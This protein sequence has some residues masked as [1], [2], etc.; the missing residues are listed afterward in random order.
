MISGGG[1]EEE[2]VVVSESSVIA[3]V[4]NVSLQDDQVEI[5]TSERAMIST[6]TTTTTT[7][8]SQAVAIETAEEEESDEHLPRVQVELDKLNYANESI[9]S[10]ELELE[11][12][13]REYLLTMEESEEELV[14]LEKRLGSCVEKSRPYYEARIDLNEAKEKYFKVHSCS[15]RHC[16][17]FIIEY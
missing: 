1:E 7:T 15:F 8:T 10:L 12:S 4:V 13:K 17:I 5:K 6:T 11:E 16:Q 3:A 9:N 2:A 14:A